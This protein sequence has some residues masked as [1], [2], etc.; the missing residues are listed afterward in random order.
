MDW[1]VILTQ[2]FCNV[3]FFIDKTI[4]ASLRPFQTKVLIYF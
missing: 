4:L 1:I 3:S 2:I